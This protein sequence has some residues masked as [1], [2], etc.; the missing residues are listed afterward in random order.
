LRGV[1]D[2][3]LGVLV[4]LLK[5]RTLYDPARRQLYAA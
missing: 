1:A 3:L 4:T 2:R 5:Q